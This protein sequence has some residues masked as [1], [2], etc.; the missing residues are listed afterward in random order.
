MGSAEKASDGRYP[1]RAGEDAGSWPGT[2]KRKSGCAATTSDWSWETEQVQAL[3]PREAP[4]HD[5]GV[6]TLSRRAG[7]VGYEQ[8]ARQ[9][10]FF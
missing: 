8:Q 9:Q 10:D 6:V 5:S 1:D 4:W 2:S 3:M 7:Q